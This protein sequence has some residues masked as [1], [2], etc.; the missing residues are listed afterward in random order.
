VNVGGS[1]H[2]AAKVRKSGLALTLPMLPLALLIEYD[3]TDYIG[4]QV[5]PSGESVQSVVQN[6]VMKAYGCVVSIVG[7][8]RTDAGVHA[9]GQVAHVHLP[10]DAN[11][12]PLH[13][14]RIAIN[15]QMPKDVRIRQVAE[16]EP[17]FH[18]R[19]GPDWR[20]YVYTIAFEERALRRRTEWCPLMTYDPTK[21][22][23][24]ATVFEGQHDF[25]SFS[26][27]NADTRSYVCRVDI[28][29]VEYHADRV[30]VRIRADRFVYGMCRAIVGA[31]MDVARGKRTPEELRAALSVRDRV[32]ASPLAPP[33]GL[34][35]NRVHYPEG[36]FDDNSYL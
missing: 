14:A 17:T 16:V 4:W 6:A 35:L 18:A 13:K 22:A 30:V 33:A 10:G 8:G 3:G 11:V 2:S 32:H 25:T 1:D 12:I 27:A 34:I 31:M 24:A 36:I 21:L 9:I 23:D 28:C 26:K 5:Q 20:E 15:V 7:A 29:R 19:Y